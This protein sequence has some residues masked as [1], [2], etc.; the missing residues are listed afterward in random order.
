VTGKDLRAA[1]DA[2]LAGKPARGGKS[3]A[4]AAASNGNRETAPLIKDFSC[5]T[6]V[7]KGSF[8]VGPGLRFAWALLRF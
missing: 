3:R 1:L 4:S 6:I 2:V 5:F 7:H 8:R